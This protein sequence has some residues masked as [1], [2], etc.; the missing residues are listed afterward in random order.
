MAAMRAIRSRFAAVPIPAGRTTRSARG[1]RQVPGANDV[2][3]FPGSSADRIVLVMT[4]SS[5]G[6]I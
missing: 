2:Y 6:D 3:A 1:S 5:R 4:T